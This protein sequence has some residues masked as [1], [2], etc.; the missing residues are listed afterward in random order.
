M[1]IFN[2]EDLDIL[3]RTIYGEARGELLKKTG[4]MKSLHA[5]A[6]VIKNRFKARVYGATIK[7]ICL[8][9]WQFSCW[10]PND[11]NRKAIEK[12]QIDNKIL[13]TCTIAA[14]EVLND[15][16]PDCT[17]GANHYHNHLISPPYWALPMFKTVKIAG[18]I[19]YKIEG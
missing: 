15:I 10:N 4:G 3:A 7:D 17:E 6:W 12:V 19:F 8:K 14:L 13:Q 16:V 1:S 2:Q 11:V 5:V 18:H 9:P